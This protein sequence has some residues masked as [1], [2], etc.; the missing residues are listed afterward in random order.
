MAEE[1]ERMQEERKEPEKGDEK[2]SGSN[3]PLII[4]IIAGVIVIEAVIL[5]VLLQMM[6]PPKPE[7]VEA[8]MKAD[9]LRHSVTE[10]TTMGAITDPPLEAVVNIAGTDGMRFLKV[11][12]VF[13]YDDTK[14]KRLGEELFRRSPKLKDKLMEQ[15]S[16]M[17]LEEINDLDARSQIRKEFMRIVNN[18][19]PEK[20]GQISNVY[21]NEFIVQ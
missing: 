2:K 12:L 14:Y 8:K 3:T 11:V 17:T 5:F 10:Q 15:L 20:V 19:L 1:D 4:G 21:L 7:E 9:S 16:A 18:T 6:K 13:E